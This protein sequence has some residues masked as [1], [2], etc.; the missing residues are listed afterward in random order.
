MKILLV[1]DETAMRGTIANILRSKGFDVVEASGGDEA[2]SL[3]KEQ[4]D[5]NLVVSDIRMPEGDGME[6]LKN[7]KSLKDTPVIIM[8]GYSQYQTEDLLDLGA[9]TVLNK[10]FNPMNFFE[11][12]KEYDK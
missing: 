4:E 8:T 7:I 5:I 11:L 6:L 2:F 3:F 1:D 12:I 9:E 10:P